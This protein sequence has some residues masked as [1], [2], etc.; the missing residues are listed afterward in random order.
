MN[1]N[2]KRS[3]E[4]SN[5]IGSSFKAKCNAHE[6]IYFKGVKFCGYLI[7]RLEKKYINLIEL[8]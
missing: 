6:I 8:I 4:I 5:E 1:E 2:S 7:S 3:N